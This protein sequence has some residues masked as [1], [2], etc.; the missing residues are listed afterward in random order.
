MGKG[1]G[2]KQLMPAAAACKAG[3]KNWRQ[4]PGVRPHAPLIAAACQGGFPSSCE[5]LLA[6]AHSRVL[7][8]S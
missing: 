1:R 4:Q 5:S 3:G 2:A 6:S 8:G 7:T